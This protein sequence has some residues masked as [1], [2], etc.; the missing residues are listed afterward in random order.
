MPSTFP[1]LELKQDGDIAFTRV[2]AV[3]AKPVLKDM[4]LYL[5]KKTP[6]AL[7]TFYAYGQK[8]LSFFG[9]TKGKDEEISQHQLPPPFE[10]GD[11][12]IYGSILLVAH[13]VKQP[14]DSAIETF[15][16]SDYEVFFEKACSGELEPEEANDEEEVDEEE[17]E[18]EVDIV[19]EEEEEEEEEEVEGDEA[20]IQ[21]IE[22]ETLED[23]LPAVTR[24]SRKT[25]KV[26]QQQ[27]QFQYVS[28]L[29]PET[30]ADRE[31]VTSVKS[32]ALTFDILLKL[33]SDIC[34]EDECLDLEMGIYNGSLEEAK[35]RLVPQT[36]DHESFRWIYTMIS[37]R[38]ISNFQPN[39][40]VRN[41]HLIERWKEGE[42][43]LQEIGHWSSYEL[44]PNFWKGL[45]D[46][47]FRREQRIL[48]GNTSMA[49]D[50][51]RCSRCQKK[52]TT[53]YEMQTRSADEPMTIFINCMNCGKQWKQ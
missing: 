36:W 16:P 24:A 46:Q 47:Q 44:H 30:D 34:T 20:I 26:D 53:Y 15:A 1:I 25:V 31:L 37:K 9:Y 39:S 51:F 50:R 28:T 45:K 17:V 43:T 33:C 8:R 41:S 48:E 32:R 29:K 38:V 19:E 7:L 5:K 4:Q 40:Y 13:A 18:P 22:E 21:P 27:I 2:K 23:I 35:K 52:M 14:W 12:E 10:S 6:P 11:V 3:G 49:T 42:F